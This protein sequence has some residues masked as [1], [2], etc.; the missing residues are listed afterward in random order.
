MQ[1]KDTLWKD[2][3]SETYRIAMR[4][5]FVNN[6]D[7]KEHGLKN[8]VH[9][10]VS[11]LKLNNATLP[12]LTLSKRDIYS[13][14]FGMNAGSEINGERPWIVFKHDTATKWEDV[15]VIPLTSALQEK[16]PDVFDVLLLKDKENN[17]YQTSYARL[18][19]LRSVSLKRIGKPIGK[20]AD[21]TIKK[22]VEQWMKSMLGIE[23]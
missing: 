1:V 11:K 22:A 23:A 2:V 9:D 10:F 14:K 18:R 13:V 4:D 5:S 17:L 6:G 20:V 7:L 15:I 12:D 3:F 8:H 16:H 21:E 19:Q